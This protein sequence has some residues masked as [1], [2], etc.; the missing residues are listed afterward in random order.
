[1]ESTEL[2]K[3]LKIKKEISPF[4]TAWVDLESIMLSNINQSGKE[5]NKHIK[6]SMQFY[7]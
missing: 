7:K 1:M 5:K 3:Q 4:P 6:I 2:E